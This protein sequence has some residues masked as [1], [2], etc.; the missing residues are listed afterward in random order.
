M[1][2]MTPTR[3]CIEVTLELTVRRRTIRLWINADAEAEVDSYSTIE[4]LH[5]LLR[6]NHYHSI[7]DV[8]DK[9]IELVPHLNAVQVID[10]LTDFKR[11]KMVYTVPFCE[12]HSS[13][14]VQ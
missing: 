4:T 14:T 10:D 9:V 3:Y 2:Q 12:D 5:T 7:D 1:G 13:G 6:P 8:I 11:G